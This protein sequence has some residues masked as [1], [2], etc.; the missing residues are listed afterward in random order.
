[1]TKLNF[2]I[3]VLRFLSLPF[4]PEK[5]WPGCEIEG[6]H[7]QQS[8]R[9]ARNS[10]HAMFKDLPFLSKPESSFS[11]PRRPE[12]QLFSLWEEVFFKQ[13]AERAF[14]DS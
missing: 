3:S 2:L 4:L 5:V 10:L 11:L 8:R 9:Q 6:S 1:M 7:Q 13:Q 14:K 12:I